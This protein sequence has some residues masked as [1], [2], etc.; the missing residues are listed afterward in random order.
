VKTIPI[1]TRSRYYGDLP[2]EGSAIKGI[3]VAFIIVF[4]VA[5]AGVGLWRLL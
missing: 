3:I 1:Y 5:V 2:V 4:F